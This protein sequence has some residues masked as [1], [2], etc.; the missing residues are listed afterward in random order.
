MPGGSLPSTPKGTIAGIVTSSTDGGVI[1]GAEVT[2]D[3]GQ[4]STTDSS[5]YYIISDVPAGECSV[6]ASAVGFRSQTKTATVSE[7]QQTTVDFALKPKKGKGKPSRKALL[8]QAIQAKRRHEKNIFQM[9]AVVG[10]GVTLSEVG[11]PV[12]EI[13]LKEDLPET[14]R[15]IPAVLDNIP[16][17]VV[18]TGEFEAF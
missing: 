10:T 18:I 12:I 8:Q 3:S 17:R 15:R 1:E 5:G 11:R 9:P 4:S 16:V 13:Y 14:R 2:V 7:N 6:K